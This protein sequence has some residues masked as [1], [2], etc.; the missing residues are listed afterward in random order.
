[1][2]QNYE[3]I[4]K[5]VHIFELVGVSQLWWQI[6]CQINQTMMK[7]V[8]LSTYR[9][10]FEA[11]ADINWRTRERKTT[12]LMITLR[13]DALNILQTISAG[14]D[15]NYIDLVTLLKMVYCDTRF[16]QVYYTQLYKS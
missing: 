4:Q 3:Q 9:R 14:A 7:K 10:Q 8:M 12:A 6:Y 15:P 1:M 13:R 16:Q 5:E 2:S 11:A